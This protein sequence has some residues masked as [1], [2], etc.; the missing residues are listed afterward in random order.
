VPP[1]ASQASVPGVAIETQLC[2]NDENVSGRTV[3]PT[4]STQPIDKNCS[5]SSCRI[6]LGHSRARGRCSQGERLLLGGTCA[7]REQ[8]GEQKSRSS[9]QESAWQKS[10][11]A[12]PV[13]IG[14]KDRLRRKQAARATRIAA[15]LWGP[16]TWRAEPV[17]N[18]PRVKRG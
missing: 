7:V 6:F 5:P 10:G 3:A 15:P 12:K 1:T 4:Y 2:S 8:P 16:L 17:C 18:W 13:R 9:A 14:V 11:L